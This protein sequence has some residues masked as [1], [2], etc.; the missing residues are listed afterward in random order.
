MQHELQHV[1]STESASAVILTLITITVSDDIFSYKL[2]FKMLI[3]KQH[4]YMMQNLYNHLQDEHK[5]ILIMK[6]HIIVKRYTQCKLE[7]SVKMQL[8]QSLSSFI[9]VLS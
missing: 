1:T 2:K 3:C 5:I 6:Q 7:K 4:Q 9:E 8:L